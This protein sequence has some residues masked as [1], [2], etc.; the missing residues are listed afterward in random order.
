MRKGFL[1]KSSRSSASPDN[2]EGGGTEDAIAN[3]DGAECCYVNCKQK[4]HRRWLFRGNGP[5]GDGP[6]RVWVGSEHKCVY[7]PFSGKSDWKLYKPS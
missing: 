2:R 7:I 3:P 6:D 1:C 4:L 5:N